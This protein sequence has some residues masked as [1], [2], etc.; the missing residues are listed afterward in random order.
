MRSPNFSS[1]HFEKDGFRGWRAAWRRFGR[2][3]ALWSLNLEDFTSGSIRPLQCKN[4]GISSIRERQV[5]RLD[6]IGLHIEKIFQLS[7]HLWDFGM[8]A[9]HAIS[10]DNWVQQPSRFSPSTGCSV[11]LSQPRWGRSG[12]LNSKTTKPLVAGLLWVKQR[13]RLAFWMAMPMS[14]SA[15]GCQPHHKRSLEPP[16]N[17]YRRNHSTIIAVVNEKIVCS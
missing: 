2:R 3:Q 7:C 16:T 17:L 6:G 9:M 1:N 10:A 5:C 15:I 12:C 4:Q 11:L 8:T 14:P 13:E